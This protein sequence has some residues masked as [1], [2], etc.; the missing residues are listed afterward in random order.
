M[1]N[2]LRIN[3]APM[4][5]K[6]FT[7]SL[8]KTRWLMTII[9]ILTLGIG[10]V[11]GGTHT[12]SYTFASGNLA[13][14][15]GNKT[16]SGKIDGST[17]KQVTWACSAA[18]A[19]NWDNN[20]G[21]QIGSS[22]NPQKNS[23][24]T[25]STA[26]S[27]I[28]SNIKITKI[29]A[30]L[31]VAN[32]GGGKYIFSAGS[33]SSG[34]NGTAFNNTSATNNEYSIP[35]GTTIS[36]GD[37]V[38]SLQST[39]NK[40]MYIKSVTITYEDV[41]STPVDPT[42]TP[43]NGEV[44]VGHNLDVSTLFESNSS[45][46]MT[47]SITA[48]GSY[49]SLT[50]STL[51]GTAVGTVTIQASQAAATGYNAKTAT[52][53]VNV[54]PELS[55]ITITQN[56]IANFTNSYAQYTWT[57]G[58]VS[59]NIYAYKNNG[60]QLN[61]G[62][63]GYYVYNTDP[64]PGKI[65]K[66]TMTK[67]SGTTR[68]WTPYV[69]T[70]AL[71][72]TSGG[73]ALTAKSVESTTTWDVTGDN[74]YFYLTLSGGATVIGSIVIT[75]EEVKNAVTVATPATGTGTLSVTGSASLSEVL[76]GTELTVSAAPSATY[77]G[78]TVKVIKTGVTP[79]VDVTSTVYNAG[80]GK[81]IMPDYAITVSATFVADAAISVAVAT[82]Q[83]SWGSVKLYDGNADEVS[84]GTTF[85]PSA[86]FMIEAIPT[87]SDYE[88]V[89]WAK[90]AG[91]DITLSDADAI[92]NDPTLTAGEVSTTFTATF[93]EAAKPYL[94]VDPES[95]TFG[96]IALNGSQNKTFG[97]TGEN[98][99]ANASLA[100]TGTGAAM[101]SVAASV[102]K[103]GDGAIDEDVTVTYNPTAAGTHTATLTVSSDG[104]VSREVALSGEAKV[105]RTVKWY[106]S[107]STEITGDDLGEATTSVLDG[108]KVT[109][110]PDAP[111]SCDA[112][113]SFQG[114]TNEPYAKSDDAPAVLFTDAKDAPAV[115]GGNA[116]YY[117]VW[118]NASGDDGSV[119]IDIETEN[120][121]T[122]YG[123]ANTFTEYTLEGYTF[124]IQ[125]MYINQG[126]IQWRS[127][128]DNNGAGT[129]YNTETFPG[130]ISS[131]V[132]EYNSDNNKNIALKIGDTEN[133]T[134][135]TSITPSVSGTYT[136]TFD[137]SDY[138]FDYFVLTNGQYAGY[139]SSVTIN[140]A[141]S[142]KDYSTTCSAP[143]VIAD[144][145]FSPEATSSDNDI[146]VSIS[147]AQG[148]T[149]YYSIGAESN[150]KTSGTAYSSAISVTEDKVIKAVATDGYGN[151]SNIVTKTYT[152]N[153][154]PSIAAYIAKAQATTRYL[155]LSAAQNCVVTAVKKNNQD[156][157]TN[158]YCQD[159]SGAGIIIYNG[160]GFGDNE[161]NVGD[162][163]VG[164]VSGTYSP[165]LKQPEMTSAVF[166]NGTTFTAVSRLDAPTV[167]VANVNSGAAYTANPMMLVTI[168]D[169]YY[170]SVNNSTYTFNTQANGEGTDITIY[171]NF[172]YL[173]GKTM[174]G[175]A[176]T[177]V[178]IMARN[179]NDYQ[180]LPVELTTAA[181]A[182]LPTIS[183]T[184]GASLEADE[185]EV[186]YLSAV[187]VQLVEN[188]DI[189]VSINDEAATKLTE[190]AS[191]NIEGDTKIAVTAKRDF[192]A[193]NSVTYYYKPSAYPQNI[194][195]TSEHGEV[196]V[197]VGETTVSTALPGATVT[198]TVTPENEHF[199][200]ASTSVTYEGGS[201]IPSLNENVYSFEMPDK[202]ATIVV[203][204]N[205]DAKYSITFNGGGAEGEG[206]AAFEDQYAGTEITLPTKEEANYTAP[207]D[208]VF[209]GWVVTSGEEE[210]EQNDGKFDMP[211]GNV[212]ITAQWADRV[213][214]ALTLNING[215]T[216][217]TNIDREVKYILPTE[218]DP[219]SG[220]DFYGWTEAPEVDD[221]ED[222]I[223]TI[224]SFTPAADEASKT[225]Y[226]VFKRTETGANKTDVITA[227][228]LAATST[229]YVEF[230]N[231]QKNS[232]AKYAGKTAKNGT[233][234]Q[235]NDAS[236]QCIISTTSGGL[237]K[238]VSITW[239]SSSNTL[240]VYASNTAY[241]AIGDLWDN[242][243]K[244]TKVTSFTATGSYNFTNDYSYVGIRSSKN[245]IQL[246]SVSITWQPSTT[247][248][249]TAPA[250]VYDVEYNLGSNPAGAWKANEGCAAT[251]VKGGQTYIICADEPV[252]EHH[253]FNGWTVG[254]SAVS[255]TIT[256]N[257]NTEIVADWI[258]KAQ[259]NVTYDAGTG[260]GSDVVVAN[261]E[262][263][264]EVT[265][266]AIGSGEGQANFTKTGYNFKGWLSNG[267]LYKAG[268][269]FE[270]PAEAVTLTA[271]WKKQNIT[272]M[273]LVTDVAQLVDGSKVV[274]VSKDPVS[275]SQTRP[276]AIAG[277]MSGTNKYFASVTEDLTFNGDNTISYNA[278]TAIELTL[279][280]VDG[281]WALRSG[282]NYLAH[283]SGQNQVKWQSDTA[284]WS[285]SFSGNN[286]TI[287]F[288][289]NYF[290]QYNAS[291]NSERFSAYSGSQ[292][293]VQLYAS[294][295]A[296]TENASI[297]EIGYVEGDVIVVSGENTTLTMDAPSAPTSITVKDG[298]TVT[299]SAQTTADN[300]TVEEGGTVEIS[301]ATTAAT[302]TVKKGAKMEIEENGSVTTNEPLVLYTTLGKGTGT[303]ANSN[304]PGS[305]S[306]IINAERLNATG[307]VYLEI[308]LTQ[309]TA[310]SYGW[311]AFSVPFQVD[312][313]NGV[314][315]GETK[316]TNEVGYAIM[317]Y[318]GDLRANGEYG[319]KKYR[320]IM[321]PGE[322][323]IITVADTEYKTLRFKKVAD[324]PL[325]ASDQVAVKKY[326]LQEGGSTG[327]NGWNGLGNPN[328]QVSYYG[329]GYMHFL[330]HGDNAFKQRTG[331]NINLVVGSAFFIQYGG[332][333]GNITITKGTQ[334]GANGYLAPAREPKA[335]EN[336]IHEVKI[337]KGDKE[338]DN[339]F[340]TARED[341]TNTYE[342]G[343]DVAKLSMGT[344]KCAQM[345]IPAYGTN[346]C[347]ADFP[348][349]NDKASYPL[350]ITTPAAGDY[351]IEL[352]E[353]YEDATIYLTYE[354]RV[355]WNLSMSPYE[356]E[357]Q[358]GQTEGYGLRLVAAPQT[359]TD[360]ENTDA[361]NGANG[362][363]KVII[364]EHVYILRGEQLF[365]VTGKA[366]R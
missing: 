5:K 287:K 82:G 220:Y 193:D 81:L 123:T 96:P 32:S 246:A 265:L 156:K 111:E 300:I 209:N 122:S 182:A 289:D 115:S 218:E 255:G 309:E 358:Q 256:I 148:M 208:K 98:L 353:A 1:K 213:Y 65:R 48:G 141:A 301:A 26:V 71:T 166:A 157:V 257:A 230:S 275:N 60:M 204:Y 25:M 194:G 272:K 44:E 117:A 268:E 79:E 237:V 325:A 43:T 54:I 103:D 146:E 263:G 36:S 124:K 314:Y 260:S 241:T 214:C 99:T 251:K 112:S 245:A 152:I 119:E 179:N 365:D 354:G 224:K 270:M 240:D 57:A 2:S 229:G 131:I 312:A 125:Q 330:E 16:F 59:G 342:T 210:V 105:L 15:A 147:A 318:H 127:G 153:Y 46:A 187:S 18:T 45:G 97:L 344:A 362:V 360:I 261:V 183:P 74:T 328:L 14:S 78:G 306:E 291:S 87:S 348:L 80:T 356:V 167:T 200:I 322:L 135:G 247:Y 91:S 42:I 359:P 160:S 181:T 175:V 41:S 319:W 320:D 207:T 136:Y 150:P 242:S 144:P 21:I 352:A 174:P 226:A 189:Y 49:A 243:K 17:T 323:Y 202:D 163:I 89:S 329:S 212:T 102:A 211:A 228:D 72:S 67:A 206:P 161:I 4:A 321:Q 29:S 238:N 68:S 203:T 205:E 13:T 363:Q 195:V 104:A 311:Y 108:G 100:I 315:F 70:S 164:A 252:R 345:M 334:G 7:Y 20:K 223:D 236:G 295:T 34:S 176:C 39:T 198:F 38:I 271:Q 120:F 292:N 151:W 170:K 188:E 159:N 266:K 12:W 134:S 101:F 338:E 296:I 332:S 109:T 126:K 253:K 129:I 185:A 85:K 244:G 276:S 92:D 165:Y 62:Q 11:W 280:K 132:V 285:I 10:N 61:S 364:D 227:A 340:F 28:G 107:N 83:S 66:I 77:H 279:D 355:I 215:A 221:V 254:G 95:L 333:D 249:T 73:T 282:D 169:L 288:G 302:V 196:V 297:S 259:S 145:T 304:A 178:G 27:N 284:V 168:A 357:L 327:D 172:S 299:V 35:S 324:A 274:I 8:L 121:P 235:I 138:S 267:V 316:L 130:H 184:G 286:A 140:Y 51:T 216:S 50:G 53:T 201:L 30:Y 90:S 232:S 88:F 149:I 128:T 76:L 162:R 335:I 269:T 294:L 331:S 64:I 234:I 6:N 171:D 197:K 199:H 303:T 143:V 264:T 293:A 339:V 56:E 139:T 133:P 273:T 22:N 262:E 298:A 290:I 219:I 69:S 317:K 337:F 351:R 75:Y 278:E 94:T 106:S 350:T 37:I 40:A 307:D 154:S 258:A 63:S 343:K 93:R 110:L 47:Y 142:I 114:W 19:I 158:I 31:S 155:R 346:L 341:A 225:L 217:T 347:A 366:A 33:A 180:I 313:M 231:V 277:P 192:Y 349:V 239:G 58:G 248:Y 186:E 9:A 116:T 190:A 336:V 281:G 177:I 55:T 361:L 86:E 118:A 84:S 137:C 23:A 310:A 3:R 24:W 113:I 326:A 308:E 283:V 191:I 222:A 173:S 52:C 305:S 250:V 233:N